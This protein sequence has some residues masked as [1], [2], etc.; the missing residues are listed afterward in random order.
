LHSGE[1]KSVLVPG[2]T[3]NRFV[4]QPT[5]L[6]KGMRVYNRTMKTT[7]TRTLPDGY[8]P[9]RTLDIRVMKNLILINLFG[10][11]LLIASWIGFAGLANAIHPGSMNFSFSSGNL[12]SLFLSLGTFL[13][14]IVAMILVHEGFHGLCFWIFTKTR[15]LF[16]FK[17]FYAYA[18]AP[19]WY[20][21]KGEY[22]ITGLAP[23]VGITVI[24]VALMFVL[25]VWW[26]TPLVWM[27]VLNTSGA[28]GDLWMVYWLLRSPADVLARDK[29]DVLEFYIKQ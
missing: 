1:T 6:G 11:V 27:L 8:R 4:L 13:I 5:N 14:V 26:M 16:A 19:E 18:A 24:C 10:V 25:P 2:Y 12:G 29:G 3:V 28:C 22:L 21:P 17:G 7:A 9:I 15:P 23:L 20:L